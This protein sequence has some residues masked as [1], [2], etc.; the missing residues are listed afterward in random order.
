MIDSLP[1]KKMPN[2]IKNVC[3]ESQLSQI[4]LTEILNN[5][6]YYP[7]SGFDGDP[8]KYL[9]GNIYSFIYI[10]YGISSDELDKEIESRGFN[11]YQV[12]LSREITERELTPNGWK[13]SQPSR[14]DGDPTK[15]KDWIK[16][17]FAKWL[18][19]QRNDDLSGEHGAERFSLLYM[20]ADGVAAFQ[21]LYLSNGCYPLGVAII[22]P[23][24][25]FGGNWTNYTNPQEI[26]ARTVLTNPAGKPKILLHGGIGRRDFYREP[27]WPQFSEHVCFLEKANGGSIG[28]WQYST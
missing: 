25:R 28:V 22:Q 2:W 26:L 7:S 9:S 19:F 12:I 10:D 21:A 20:C 1:K 24:H 15:Y 8:I 17:P 5:S 14:H 27:C 13:P 18:V 6:L 4:P 11:G 3:D 16:T 23:G